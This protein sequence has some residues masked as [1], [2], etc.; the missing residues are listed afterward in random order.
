MV[1]EF[2]YAGC[3]NQ[4]FYFDFLVCEF[5]QLQA[6]LPMAQIR[7]LHL[8]E[9]SRNQRYS[10]QGRSPLRRRPQRHSASPDFHNNPTNP[11]HPLLL[12]LRSHLVHPLPC[13][14][15]LHLLDAKRLHSIPLAKQHLNKV[16]NCRRIGLHHLHTRAD[17]RELAPVDTCG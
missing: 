9:N 5:W 3:G 15:S 17:S 12:I 14:R 6:R 4:E 2:K 7:P 11:K 16:Q 13:T 8:L 10:P 1:E